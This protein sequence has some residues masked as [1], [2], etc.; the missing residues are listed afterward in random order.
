L[1]VIPKTASFAGQP[2]PH[3]LAVP[4]EKVF[5]VQL[6][7]LSDPA[8]SR[9]LYTGFLVALGFYVAGLALPFALGFLFTVLCLHGTFHNSQGSVH[10]HL[11]LITL[12]V[13][14]QWAAS[15]RALGRGGW[16]ALFVS[17]KECGPWLVNWSQQVIVAA[18]VVSA[19]SKIWLSKGLWIWRTPRIGVQLAK[20][21]DQAYYDS[22]VPGTAA[23][24]WLPAW[25]VEHPWATRLIFGAA[26]PLEFCAFLALR[27]R[28]LGTLY[29]LALVAFHISVTS[30][31]S[32]DFKFNV[33]MLIVF[34]VNLPFWTWWLAQGR[35]GRGR[36][37]S[38]SL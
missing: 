6:T 14:A 23:Y 5:G 2:E 24:T 11:Q 19:L 28:A 37:L 20:A 13:G 7:F 35:G 38:L 1:S 8:V 27:N 33:Q 9:R 34:F 18:Y 15:L 4:L 3:G 10:H 26:L 21:G 31:M 17:G 30:L 12:V 32:L 16:R 25:C 22:L 36:A 29:A